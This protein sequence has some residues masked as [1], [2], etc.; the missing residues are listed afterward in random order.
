MLLL[1][2]VAVGT[3]LLFN[4]FWGMSSDEAIKYTAWI[5]IFA[6][7]CTFLFAEDT[8]TKCDASDPLSCPDSAEMYGA[9]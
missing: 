4:V 2:G 6:C 1:V 3:Y 5:L 8:P 9:R 7:I